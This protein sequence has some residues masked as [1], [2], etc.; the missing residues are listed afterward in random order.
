[1]AKIYW[2]PSVLMRKGSLVILTILLLL[3]T[4]CTFPVSQP[5]NSADAMQPPTPKPSTDA[6][7]DIVETHL[8]TTPVPSP[9]FTSVAP[10]SQ[11]KATPAVATPSEEPAASD[12]KN[13]PALFFF[14]AD[15]CSAC[16]QMRPVI[17]KLRS[18]YSD[19]IRFVMVDVDDPESRELV[20]M[21]GVR[22][23]P[24]TMLI[25]SPDEEAQRW[26][27]PRPEAVMRAALDQVLQ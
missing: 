17:E 21:V 15:W 12:D 27:G 20:S 25:T 16:G 26:V 7:A 18:E 23:I 11:P 8:P 1:M 19:R 10:K 4:G 24:L 22:A 5:G 14:Y 13:K 2:R 9:T 6:G 3:A